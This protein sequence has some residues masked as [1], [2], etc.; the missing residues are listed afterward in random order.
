MNPPRTQHLARRPATDGDIPLLVQL[1]RETMGPHELAAGIVV[2]EERLLQRVMAYFEWASIILMGEQP[3]GLLKV[4]RQSLDWELVQLQIVPAFQGR[5]LG[6]L[7]VQELIAEAQRA[8]ATLRLSVLKTNPARRLYE[9]LG[10]V[11]VAEKP[12]AL[13]M[14]LAK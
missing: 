10:F 12:A 8:G 2:C 13:V 5:G 1:R 3:I 14:Q 6:T 11:V 9:R 7:I 4:V